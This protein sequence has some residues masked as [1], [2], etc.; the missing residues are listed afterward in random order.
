M[1]NKAKVLLLLLV[2]F[3]L[4][5]TG[6]TKPN[7]DTTKPTEQDETKK[8]ED[9]K[10]S[11]E[12]EVVSSK[13]GP[14]GIVKVEE[15]QEHYPEIVASF[16]KNSEMKAS[17]YGGSEPHD[18]LEK[19][20]YLKTFYEGFVFAV[21]YD[22]ARGH[23]YA[24]E[25]VVNTARPKKGASC[26]DCKVSQYA[27]A[28]AKDKGA[29]MANF[30]EFVKENVTVG[31]TCYDCH[32]EEPGVVHLNRAHLISALEK[33][34]NKEQLTS[35]QTTCAQCHVD[36]YMTKDE[37]LTTL[38]WDQ[39]LGCDKAYA[40]QQANGFYDW[41][42]PKTGAKLIKAQHPE[43]ETFE[44]SVHEK[45]GLDCITCHMPTVE[46]DGK[47]IKSHHWTSPLFTA[48]ES[49]LSCHFNMDEQ[50]IVKLAESI[51]K[52]VVEMTEEVALK[53][54][55]YINKLAAK[56][57]DG[58]LNGENLTKCQDIHREAQFYWD[59]VFVEN[60]EGFHNNTKQKE[61][62]KHADELIDEGLKLLE[63]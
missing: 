14:K 18:Y 23:S 2:I 48:K 19:Y 33:N 59:Y 36:Y 57:E 40:H 37:N 26:L 24:L 42:H 49:C 17:T 10:T 31:F 50:G 43:T 39:G 13:E 4:I 35:K 32:G 63:V 52:P 60:G 61:Y 27:E 5:V 30:E 6:C 47:K 41:E 3:S 58:S 21:Q 16:N 45:M 8:P 28:L 56:K 38:P 55:D 12:S 20:P 9:G 54:E 34:D 53:L 7:T 22:R 44:G 62:L 25:D 51:Q 11:G 15:W 1:R 29:A 46:Q